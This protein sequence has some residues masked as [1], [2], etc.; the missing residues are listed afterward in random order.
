MCA[1]A[2]IIGAGPAGLTA[3]LELLRTTSVRPIVLEA[4]DR[5]GGISATLEHHGNRIDIGGHRFFSTSPR[6]LDWW[7][8]FLPRAT[9]ADADLAPPGVASQCADQRRM[10]LRERH[11]H[12]LF[13]GQTIAYP[14]RADLASLKK[15]GL[16]RCLRFGASYARSL[17]G[18]NAAPDS[19]EAFF[20]GRFGRALYE[21]F[22]RSYTQKVWGMAPHELSAAWGAER[23]GRLSVATA[24]RRSLRPAPRPAFD[25]SGLRTLSSHFLYPKFGPGQL[26]EAVAEEIVQRG[27]QI[28]FDRRVKTLQAQDGQIRSVIASSAAGIEEDFGADFVVST[29]PIQA[30]VGALRPAAPPVVTG[31]AQRLRYRSSIIIG[32]LLERLGPLADG[33]PVRDQWL[34]VQEPGVKLGRVQF[35]NNWSRALV[36]DPTR[37]WIGLEYFCDEDDAL[38]AQSDEALIRLG[39]HEGQA[40]GLLRPEDLRDGV[41]IR[42]PQTYPVYADGYH[43]LETVTSWLRRFPNLL[44]AGRNGCHRYVNQD[45]A[46]LSAMEAVAAIAAQAGARAHTRSHPPASI[47]RCQE[48]ACC[49]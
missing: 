6:I 27:G 44:L 34:Y 12:I 31:I 33:G 19:L 17:L 28:L 23:I 37:P 24:M 36:A 16:R 10:L 46:M 22:F 35:F 40:I 41:V 11:S 32:L 29:M 14:L 13:D 9:E 2:V 4:S 49:I 38:W 18:P 48:S 8:H 39:L 43:Q 47:G 20:V 5:V 30:L 3:A 1:R 15:L 26:W 25:P 45:G 7:D 42:Y 21:T